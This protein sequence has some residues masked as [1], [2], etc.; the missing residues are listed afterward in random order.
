MKYKKIKSIAV[1]KKAATN[2]DGNY[3]EFFIALAGGLARSSKSISYSPS[4]KTFCISNEID[5]SFEEELTE[6]ELK[7]QTNI[8]T[9]I[10]AGAFYQYLF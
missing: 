2:K 6:E 9:A 4:G 3:T 8:Y 5:D 7:S 1:L 10:K